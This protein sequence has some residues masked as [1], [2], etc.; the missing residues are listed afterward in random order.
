MRT[1]L[2]AMLD[3]W[4]THNDIS[5]AS[6]VEKVLH[7]LP[8]PLANP[9]GRT[10]LLE[11]AARHVEAALSVAQDSPLSPAS[12]AA[13]IPTVVS[14]LLSKDSASRTA[15]QKLLGFI[16]RVCGRS[17]VDK[18][19]KDLKPA[20]QR[21]VNDMIAAA[22]T[23]AALVEFA[24]PCCALIVMDVVGFCISIVFVFRRQLVEAAVCRPQCPHRPKHPLYPL[25]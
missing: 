11:W 6:C 21:S 23:A 19:A 3:A 25:Q 16:I 17:G 1:S 20:E 13:L 12:L 24:L 7:A 18:A 4:V 2:M 8:E 22:A 10:E 9:N 15:S 14:C 5:V